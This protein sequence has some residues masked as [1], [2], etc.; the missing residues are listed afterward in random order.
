[1]KT[2][3]I[4]LVDDHPSIRFTFQMAL[5]AEGHA[6]EL[7]ASVEE[8]LVKTA[9]RRFDLLILDLRLGMDSGL[10]LLAELRTRGVDSFVLMMTAHG[11]VADAVGAMKLGAID[12]L[13]KP[14]DPSRLRAAVVDIIERQ[15]VV[16]NAAKA[17]APPAESYQRQIIEAKHALNCRDFDA[18][19]R[20]LAGAL[21]IDDHSADAH[22]LYGV[23]L[24][25]NHKR[26]DA[27][28]Y[29][30]RA[31]DLYAEHSLAQAQLQRLESSAAFPVKQPLNHFRADQGGS[32]PA[33]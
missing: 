2:F 7:A 8:T 23:L 13:Q 12:F 26:D 18:A 3:H 17:A 22:Y 16:A 31:L 19:R 21:E 14:L 29:Y 11:T 27:R 33:R 4:L 15:C 25:L 6:V 28:R 9:R 20:Y 24:E 1:M 32:T 30:K 5:E 10:Q